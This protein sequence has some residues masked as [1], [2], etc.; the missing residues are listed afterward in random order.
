MPYRISNSHQLVR[1]C[2]VG[3]IVHC[4]SLVHGLAEAYGRRKPLNTDDGIADVPAHQV[5][6]GAVERTITRVE[7][8]IVHDLVTQTWGDE[9]AMVGRHDRRNRSAA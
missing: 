3:C 2:I 1:G 8:Q 9:I 5:S 4:S 6:A 7:A